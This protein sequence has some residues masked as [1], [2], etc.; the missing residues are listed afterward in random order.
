M[1]VG[2]AK[3]HATSPG[4]TVPESG[5]GV[6]RLVESRGP[7]WTFDMKICSLRRRAY[8]ASESGMRGPAEHVLEEVRSL[9]AEI[10]R[11]PPKASPW[12]P[13][14]SVDRTGRVPARDG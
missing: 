12:P 7:E 9:E 8:E 14:S 5:G 2:Y 11:G 3:R 1:L 13:R 6:R 10:L 4:G